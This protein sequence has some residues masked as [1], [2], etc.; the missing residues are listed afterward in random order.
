MHYLQDCESIQFASSMLRYGD[1]LFVGFGGLSEGR[2][3]VEG[4]LF[5]GCRDRMITNIPS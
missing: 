3:W 5:R 4:R 2:S 1:E